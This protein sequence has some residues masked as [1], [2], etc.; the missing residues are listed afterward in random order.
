[1]IEPL[2]AANL[3][4]RLHRA[5][6][7]IPRAINQ[8]RDPRVDEG[9]GAHGTRFQ[10]HEYARAFE[11]PMAEALRGESNREELGVGGG[12]GGLFT[13]VV[14]ACEDLAAG[15]DDDAADWNITMEHGAIGFGERFAHPVLVAE[16]RGICRRFLHVGDFAMEARAR[17]RQSPLQRG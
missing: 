14:L 3:E 15:A 11:S 12:I 9:A 7:G 13:P 16:K 2:I 1:M 17:A 6:F 5:G 4:Q 10:G 8:T